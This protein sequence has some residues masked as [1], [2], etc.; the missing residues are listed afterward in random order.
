VLLVRIRLL[1]TKT[2][3]KVIASGLLS[4]LMPRQVSVCIKPPLDTSPDND[5]CFKSRKEWPFRATPRSDPLINDIKRSRQRSV[6]QRLP[7]AYLFVDLAK[8]HSL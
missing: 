4:V 1:R 5:L 6:F 3:L 8:S 2:A 7:R